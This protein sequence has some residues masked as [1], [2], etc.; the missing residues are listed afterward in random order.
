[1]Q[2]LSVN[3][4]QGLATDKISSLW[5]AVLWRNEILCFYNHLNTKLG[6]I[7]GKYDLS[8][9]VSNL[10]M[11][12]SKFSPSAWLYSDNGRSSSCNWPLRREPLLE[13]CPVLSRI[14]LAEI[15]ERSSF[16]SL[17]RDKT[18]FCSYPLILSYY[19]LIESLSLS[20]HNNRK[21]SSFNFSSLD[22]ISR[23][24]PIEFRTSVKW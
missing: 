1:M 2:K 3:L 13:L 18:I 23:T 16:S 7:S 12:G 8:N 19:L 4:R 6:T 5:K 11:K 20:F 10:V 9:M 14:E 21:I 15:L 17:F 24:L 22:R